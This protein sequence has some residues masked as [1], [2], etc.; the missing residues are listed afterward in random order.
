M[1]VSSKSSAEVAGRAEAGI[2][3]AVGPAGAASPAV[4]AI[5]TYK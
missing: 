1:T 4:A 5:A 3:A 2:V